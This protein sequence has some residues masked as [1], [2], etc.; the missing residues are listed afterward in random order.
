VIRKLMSAV[1]VV[2]GVVVA[3]A[4]QAFALDCHNVSRAVSPAEYTIATTT[5]PLLS[6]DLGSGPVGEIVWNVIPYL[7][8]NW[9]LVDLTE[10]SGVVDYPHSPIVANAGTVIQT[11]AVWWGFIPPGTFSGAPG[12]SGN[13]TNGQ[14]D[15]LLGMSACPTARQLYQ[16]IQSGACGGIASAGL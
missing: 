15:D 8:G 6:V 16:G 1:A 14:V 11:D 4:P 10:N 13:Y 7:K 3:L 5:T 2:G 12:G 9:Y